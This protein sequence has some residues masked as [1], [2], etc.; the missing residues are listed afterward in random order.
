MKSCISATI[1]LTIIMSSIYEHALAQADFSKYEVGF[2]AGTFIYQ[3]DL[4]PQQLGS[5]KTVKPGIGISGTRILTPAFAVRLNLNFGKLKGDDARYDDPA[6]RKQRNF[7]FTTPV[8][9]LSVHL[10]YDIFRNNDYRESGG[11]SPYIFAGAGYTFVNIKRDY[12]RMDPVL[13]PAEG[14]VSNGLSQ[15]IGTT[16]PRRIF[17][18]PIGVGV[19]KFITGRFSVNLETSYRLMS[20]DYLDGFSKSVNPGKNDHYHYTSIGIIYSFRKK[21]MLGCPVIR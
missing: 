4:T 7:N 19:R 1:C 18:V 3:G 21:D 12:S 2:N 14:E 8:T 13:F 20:T 10:L 17:N 9:E 16:L 11:L 15:D 6:Y 5:F